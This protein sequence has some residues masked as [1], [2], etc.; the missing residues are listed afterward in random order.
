MNEEDKKIDKPRSREGEKFIEAPADGPYQFDDQ[1]SP[2][3]VIALPNGEVTVR[4][5]IDELVDAMA[6]CI[7]TDAS[8]SVSQFDTF[9]LALSDADLLYPLYE[10]LMYD[11]NVRGLPWQSTHLWRVD[12]NLGNAVQDTIIDH[13][14]IPVEQVHNSLPIQGKDEPAPRID[15]LVVDNNSI[16]PKGLQIQKIVMIA[17]SVEA[18]ESFAKTNSGFT[19]RGFVF[20]EN[21]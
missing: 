11:P 17:T 6:A 1:D 9:Q 4:S 19:I 3:E 15:C 10:R 2:Q 7:F 5:T 21:Q 20:Q 18:C 8:M 12:K 14:D 16:V 13:A